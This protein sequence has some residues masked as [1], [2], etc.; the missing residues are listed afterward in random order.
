LSGVT[1]E[2]MK[3]AKAG[4]SGTGSADRRY[5]LF[6]LTISPCTTVNGVPGLTPSISGV[7]TAGCRDLDRPI[8]HWCAPV[9]TSDCASEA[10]AVL[11][12]DVVPVVLNMPP[13]QNQ[14]GV[15]AAAAGPIVHM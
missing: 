4:L 2:R 6:Q 13:L 7:N 9:I 12:E 5:S 15:S 1:A 8:R 14:F 3:A 11:D 10:G